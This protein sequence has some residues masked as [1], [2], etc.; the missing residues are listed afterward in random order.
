[1]RDAEVTRHGE[2]WR[3]LGRT[4]RERYSFL[5]PRKAP[6]NPGE[7]GLSRLLTQAEAAKALGLGRLIIRRAIANGELPYVR[8]T[9]RSQARILA[10]DLEQWVRSR[11]QRVAVVH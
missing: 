7:H 10:S 2:P 4:V 3:G 1:M 8:L 6:L 9:P 11:T 5:V